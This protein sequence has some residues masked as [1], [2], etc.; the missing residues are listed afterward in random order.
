MQAIHSGEFPGKSAVVFMPIIDMDPTDM[1]CIYLTLDFI[2]QQAKKY[3]AT[4]VVTFDQ[5]LW[6]KAFS[7]IHAEPTGSDLKSIIVRLGGLHLQMSFLG[8]IGDLMAGS[9]LEE[10]LGK[11]YAN[12]A[13]KHMLSGKAIARAMRGHFLVNAAL[14]TVLVANAYNV[15]LPQQVE[16]PNEP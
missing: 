10:V 13:V 14:N 3:G 1:S 11:V 4:P 2:S 9:G 16:E 12:N 6:W 5:P 15:P 7:I 8:C